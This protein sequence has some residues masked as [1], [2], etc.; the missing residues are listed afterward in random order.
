M[1]GDFGINT[2]LFETNILNLAVVLR[3]VVKVLGDSINDLLDKRRKAILLM[4]Q[5]AD[6]KKIGA[7][8]R[9]EEARNVVENARTRA[10]EIREEAIRLSEDM[11]LAIK[12]I[13]KEDLER[14]NEVQKRSIQLQRENVVKSISQQVIDLAL[15][16]TED[17]LLKTFVTDEASHS[18]QYKL[19]QACLQ[20]EFHELGRRL[21]ND[22]KR[23][24]P[25][26]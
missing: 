15:A 3:I 11:D 25:I 17:K 6:K 1:R 2:D 20:E 4:L 12:K 13:L 14:L 16:D 7:Q 22:P 18:N 23:N 8:Y 21:P 10:Q 24:S 26:L 19:N 5:E 9:R